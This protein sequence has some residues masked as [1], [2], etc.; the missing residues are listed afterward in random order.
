MD[1]LT[2]IIM[3]QNFL[4][5][6][7]SKDSPK[8]FK[9]DRSPYVTGMKMFNSIEQSLSKEAVCPSATQY[10]SCLLWD[11]KVQYRVHKIPL[12]VPILKKL[13]SPHHPNL[14]P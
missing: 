3:G 5:Q 6:G 4:A 1:R 13:F 11:P 2:H 9:Q 12:T 14:F 8:I 7:S 10:I